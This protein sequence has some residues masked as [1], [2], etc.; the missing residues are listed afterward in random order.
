MLSP[1][2]GCEAENHC[3]TPILICII[4]C[5]DIFDKYYLS[6]GG[7]WWLVGCRAINGN[8]Q[9]LRIVDRFAQSLR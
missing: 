5:F 8:K 7:G 3:M 1:L 4:V 9:S 2:N 6:N